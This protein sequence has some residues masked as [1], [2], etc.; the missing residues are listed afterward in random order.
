MK[1]IVIASLFASVMAFANPTGGTPAAQG[2]TG[3]G[4]A[5]AET[6]PG[7]TT[8]H[9][10]MGHKAKATTTDTK[11]AECKTKGADGKCMDEGAMKK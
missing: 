7:K 5:T 9:A 1:S 11:T 4:T 3:G 8:D 10:K 2:T 6:A